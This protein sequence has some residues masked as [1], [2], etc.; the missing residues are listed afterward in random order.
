MHTR[1]AT[2]RRRSSVSTEIRSTACNL[3]CNDVQLCALTDPSHP[4]D[5]RHPCPLSWHCTINHL[6]VVPLLSKSH[7][8]IPWLCILIKSS[9]HL[10]PPAEPAPCNGVGRASRAHNPYQDLPLCVEHVF[11]M[12]ISHGGDAMKVRTPTMVAP[13]RRSEKLDVD[14]FVLRKRTSAD[15]ALHNLL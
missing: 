13:T 10:P 6:L 7:S 5:F 14:A 2:L 3:C 8:S 9:V 1:I 15:K 11:Q 12:T 4:S